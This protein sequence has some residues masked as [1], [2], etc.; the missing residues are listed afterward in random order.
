MR[1]EKRV[2]TALPVQIINFFL[3]SFFYHYLVILT[4][5]VRRGTNRLRQRFFSEKKK[6]RFIVG[7]HSVHR[8]PYISL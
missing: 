1:L 8:N 7:F 5:Y 4:Y 3:S 2:Y 6:N